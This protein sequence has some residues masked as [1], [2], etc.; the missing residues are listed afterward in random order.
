MKDARRRA[1]ANTAM[2]EEINAK[3]KRV[4]GALRDPDVEHHGGRRR[5][6]GDTIYSGPPNV[7]ENAC[8]ED[9]KKSL[10]L[11]EATSEQECN[12]AIRVAIQWSHSV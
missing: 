6:T 12:D 2:G 8:Y 5:S 3:E 7:E 9:Y 1:C 4:E 11:W 10:S